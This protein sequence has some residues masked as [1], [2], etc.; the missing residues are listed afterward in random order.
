MMN[1][2]DEQIS[3]WNISKA[4]AMGCQIKDLHIFKKYNLLNDY[5]TIMYTILIFGF[6]LFFGIV[7]IFLKMLG[8]I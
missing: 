7:L 4:A 1:E 5:T 3:N 6:G 8:V 2:T